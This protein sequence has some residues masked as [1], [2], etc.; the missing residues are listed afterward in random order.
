MEDN[1]T[2]KDWIASNSL[3][4]ALSIVA[5][6]VALANIWLVGQLS[7]LYKNIEVNSIR[8]EANERKLENTVPREEIQLSLE[9]INSRLDDIYKLLTDHIL[10]GD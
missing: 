9:N 7:P 4:L 10:D 5:F 2:F 3:Q 1:K 6:L 8:I